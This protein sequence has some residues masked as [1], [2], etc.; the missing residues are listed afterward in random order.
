MV[1]KFSAAIVS[2]LLFAGLALNPELAFAI[3][4]SAENQ[5]LNQSVFWQE[6]GDVYKARKSLEK[7]LLANPS[8]AKA[9]AKI[10]MLEARAGNRKEAL[11]YLKRLR[12]VAPRHQSIKKIERALAVNPKKIRLIEQARAA[13]SKGQFENS[14]RLYQKLYAKKKPKGEQAYEYYQTAASLSRY[15]SFSRRGLESLVTQ[16]PGNKKYALALAKHLTYRKATRMRG[17]AMLESQVLNKR[18]TKKTV[19]VWRKAL[20]WLPVKL[21]SIPAY[22]AYLKEVGRD[23]GVSAL[24]AKAKLPPKV[25]QADLI[26]QQAFQELNQGSTAKAVDLFTALLKKHKNDAD[27]HGG[28]GVALL[29]QKQ[30]SKA[31][32]HLKSA[33]KLNKYAD[34]RWNKALYNAQYWGLL[35]RAKVDVNKGKLSA[36]KKKLVKAVKILPQEPEGR[37]ALARLQ[38][39]KGDNPQAIQSLE[40]LLLLAPDYYPARFALTQLKVK[41]NAI[42]GIELALNLLE[43]YPGKQ[44]NSQLFMEAY[45]RY[46]QKKDILHLSQRALAALEKNVVVNPDNVWA[47]LDLANMYRLSGQKEQSLSLLNGLIRLYPN[48]TEARYM[49]AQLDAEAGRWNDAE[50][51]LQGISDERMSKDMLVLSHKIEIQKKLSQ[52]LLLA[53]E[54]RNDDAAVILDAINTKNMLSDLTNLTALANAWATIGKPFKALRIG[55]QMIH[56][57]PENDYDAKL[58]YVSILITA[59]EGAEAD[60]WL[61]HL[62]AK[63][64]EMSEKQQQSLDQLG[65]GQAIRHSDQARLNKDFAAAWN[66]LEPYLGHEPSD[67]EVM[68][69]LARIY[70]DAKR[71]RE[72]LSIYN[73]IL[74]KEPD[75]KNAIEAAAYSATSIKDFKLAEQLINR[76]MTLEPE[77]ER[78]YMMQGRLERARGN[79]R[80]ALK[81]FEKV[82]ELQ[83]LKHIQ[84]RAGDIQSP[85][86]QKAPR[87]RNPFASDEVSSAG[88]GEYI[89]QPPLER[90]FQ[91]PFTA[92]KKQR[93]RG[94]AFELHF[95]DAFPQQKY[96]S[97][98]VVQRNKRVGFTS[99][100][101]STSVPSAL[102]YD[103]LSENDEINREISEVRSGLSTVLSTGLHV[104]DRQGERGLSQLNNIEVPIKLRLRPFGNTLHLKMTP[105]LLSSGEV[106]M[107]NVNLARRFGSND[108]AAILP[109]NRVLEQRSLGVAL[110]AAYEIGGLKADMGVSPLGFSV[111]NFIGGIAYHTAIDELQFDVGL[112]RRS[113]TDSFL[114]YAGTR[115]PA[116][117]Q[118]W[119][120]V[121]K[122]AI[123]ADLTYA[124]KSGVGIYGK[125]EYGRL[126]GQKVLQNNVHNLAIGSYGTFFQEGD[127]TFRAGINLSLLGYSKNLQYYTLGHGGYFSPQQY[128]AISIPVNFSD[129][130]GAL[131]YK[132]SGYL[133]L[134]M[135]QEDSVAYYP[136]N[137]QLQAASGRL[138]PGANTSGFL[139]GI[140]A[141]SEYVLTRNLSVGGNLG[142][143][144]A[145]NYNQINLGVYMHYRFDGLTKLPSFRIDQ[146]HPFYDQ[147]I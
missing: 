117:N 91:K 104:R 111:T 75:N 87:L 50:D 51:A 124:S 69:A 70:H 74:Q 134:H 7:L 55:R 47:R 100:R 38:I 54:G 108:V 109:Q 42:G 80:N 17:I 1:M 21:E 20:F 116:S 2:A 35:E 126:T 96:K 129:V 39:S 144:N 110:Q 135:F 56:A 106:N 84:N 19:A 4:K 62:L 141:A 95:T 83:R 66:S 11:A 81:A 146:L 15:W 140:D 86:I 18:S 118:I 5:L 10:A 3:N 32:K 46:D 23:R 125:L 57:A 79:D 102:A 99:A 145:R 113:I 98:K 119:G 123:S 63:R 147:G 49:K 33:V 67:T 130:S 45:S 90:S 43:T 52:A 112:S 93:L 26:K 137:P 41:G 9:L 59:R 78:F 128:T 44:G 142:F 127:T 58:V 77:Q 53:K 48:M 12:H 24:I 73:D 143:D 107:R 103:R 114:S 94:Q 92:M 16:F 61:K 31:E 13:A 72:A 133:G 88:Q 131:S 89:S 121:V 37:M 68:L 120:G 64:A 132:I 76:G 6:S 71:D 22:E 97:R 82:K 40:S 101:A 138:Y 136:N 30:F 28:L 105:V 36:A 25:K 65:R 115:D 29:K 122:S 14:V 34:Q 85:A 27:V 8:H 139:L 60:I